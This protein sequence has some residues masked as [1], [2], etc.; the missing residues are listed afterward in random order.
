MSKGIETRE[1]ILEKAF[2]QASRDGL[3]GLSIG[4][5]A[6]SLAMSKSGL[7]AHFGSKEAL[8]VEVL[9]STARTFEAEVI[10]PALKSPRGEARVVAL[11]GR[12]VAWLLG[13]AQECGC[14]F[15]QASVELDDRPGPAREF[16]VTMQ[17]QFLGVLAKAARIAVEDGQFRSDLDSKL[18]AFQWYGLVQVWQHSRRLLRDPA[19]DDLLASGF[20]HLLAS[21]RVLARD[22]ATL[23]SHP[24]HG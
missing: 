5:L 13:P 4:S 16:L 11:H 23:P 8:Q 22:S 18:F 9:R 15:M 10:A 14:L 7:F 1:R 19:A 20:H 24:H 12:W 17:R 6:E 2:R 21:S 3:E